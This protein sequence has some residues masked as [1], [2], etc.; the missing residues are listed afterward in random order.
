MDMAVNAYKKR[1]WFAAIMSLFL[2]FMVMLSMSSTVFAGT[3]LDGGRGN[4][5]DNLK[6]FCKQATLPNNGQYTDA[7]SKTI[8]TSRYKKSGGGYYLYTEMADATNSEV[9]SEAKYNELTAGAKK[10][11]LENYI[12]IANAWSEAVTKDSGMFNSAN[13]ITEDT[14]NDLLEEVQNTSGAGSQMLAS[15]LQNTKPDFVTANRIYKPFSGIV[16][17]VLG[18]ISILIMALLGVTIALD[19]AY[20]VIPAF[21]LFLDG[22]SDG[23][24]AQ[25][26]AAKGMARII[27]QEAR[28]AVKSVENGGGAGGQSGSSNKLAIS[29]YAKHR[30]K[31]MLVL[32]V[33]LL[34]LVQG[35]IYA[36]VAW[37]I[38][39]MSGFLGF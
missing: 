31:S 9:F 39:L 28:N 35:Q 33:C 15:L 27:S 18:V 4:P 21:Q 25:S 16:G 3:T 37:V 32:G 8:A 22:D 30:W 6:L 14:V 12:R 17:T 1:R 23:G 29:V 34:Y 20:I 11:Y 19:I 2:V 26:G 24:G 36:F 38:D 13:T 5:Y 10:S 7:D